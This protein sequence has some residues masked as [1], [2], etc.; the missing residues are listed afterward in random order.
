MSTATLPEGE[1]VSPEETLSADDLAWLAGIA[2]LEGKIYGLTEPRIFTPPLRDVDHDESATLGFDV[3]DFSR[4]VLG[5]EPTPWQQWWLRHALELREDGSLRFSTILTLVARQNGKTFLLILVSLYFLY[6]RKVRLV[7]GS[8]Q[9]VDTA[10]ESWSGAYDLADQADPDGDGSFP[11]RT[12]FVH[13]YRGK[14]G[15]WE[16]AGASELRLRPAEGAPSS[17]I[18]RYKVAA[19][20]AG[21][22]RGLSV[23]LLILDELRQQKDSKAWAAL[24]KTTAARPDALTVAIS[25]AGEADSVVLNKLRA[26]AMSGASPDIAIFEWSAPDGCPLTD[27][28]GWRQ[29]NPGL[30]YYRSLR[31]LA[32]D[33]LIDEAEVFR[34]ECLCQTVVALDTLV[35]PS[36][37]KGCADP[38]LTLDSVRS[39]VVACFEVAPDSA[40]AVLVSAA[41]LDDGRI[42]LD[43]VKAWKD[44]KTAEL[45]LPELLARVKPKLFGWFPEGPAAEM[46]TK[47][48]RVRGQREIKGAAVTESCQEYV[49]AIHRDAV[50][51]RNDPLLSTHTI[52]ARKAPVSDGYRFTRK[53]GHVD[54][55]YA[56]AGARMLAD[57][58]S[59]RSDSGVWVV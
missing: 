43:V 23:D 5:V 28:E 21:A 16:G 57:N 20:T 33:M 24:S 1:I 50:R 12:E 11:L 38:H 31:K 40:H 18:R 26:A 53:G 39:R 25:N 47:L 52:A 8:A 36:A 45:E 14:A 27:I 19:S 7:L 58:V 59:I 9:K 2:E 46:A 55:A 49:G 56:A 10:K 34:T 4:G 42:G 35:N 32:V 30:G 44:L 41:K 22:G 3:I 15:K 54:A 13:N 29:A 48:R 6:V 37:W 51:H 17:A